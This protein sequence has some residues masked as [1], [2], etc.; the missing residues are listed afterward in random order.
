MNPVAFHL[1]PLE[2][3]WY[4]IMMALSMMLAAA[5]S[6]KLLK[7]TGRRGDLVWDGLVYIILAGVIGARLVY[8]LT[9]LG[10]YRGLPLW[11]LIAVWEGGLSFHGGIIAGMIATWAYF[12]DK[13]IPF[14]EIMDSFAPG[15]S[16]GI[17]CVRIGNTM[18]GD[19]LGYK[20][21]GPWAMNFPH[22]EFHVG[23]PA[24]TIILRHPTELYGLMVGVLCLLISLWLWNLT[25]VKHKFPTG[26]A[27]MGF[28]I[29]Y[30]FIR[31]VIEEPFRAVPLVWPITPLPK[32]GVA[33]AGFG[34]LTTTQAASIILIILGII[35]LTRLRAWEKARR[36]AE[37]AGIMGGGATGPDGLTRQQRRKQEREQRKKKGE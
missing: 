35:G 22:D 7:K 13:G 21:K 34:A 9:N 27:Y 17:V 6:A 15:V 10:D 3:R 4:G 32:D 16:L 19:I 37:S 11:H 30:S 14:V 26:A 36:D 31:S 33:P 18:N 24:G 8:V 28:V 23:Q 25:Y 5:I 2:I 29:A 20:W 12:K 1:G